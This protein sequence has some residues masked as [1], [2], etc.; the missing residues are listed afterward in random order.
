MRELSTGR[1]WAEYFFDRGDWN[2]F[3]DGIY[4]L[5]NSNCPGNLE[6]S[7]GIGLS[8]VLQETQ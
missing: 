3:N 8:L 1:S 6:K 7:C 5:F 2:H 4:E